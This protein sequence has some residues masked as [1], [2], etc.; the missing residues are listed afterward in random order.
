MPITVKH[1]QYYI[2]NAQCSIKKHK[3]TTVVSIG[4]NNKFEKKKDNYI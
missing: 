3:N 2:L 4:P 1:V